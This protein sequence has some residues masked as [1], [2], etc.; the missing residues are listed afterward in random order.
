MRPLLFIAAIGAASLAMACHGNDSANAAPD[1]ALGA[2]GA[3]C[4]S[5]NDCDVPNHFYCLGP[6]NYYTGGCLCENAPTCTQDAQCDAG[7]VCRNVTSGAGNCHG[8]ESLLCAAPCT[9]DGD[10]APTDS[11]TADGHCA[12]RT[13][14][15]CPSYFSCST[16]ACTDPTC[17]SDTDC[18]GGYCVLGSC[19]VSL[20]ACTVPCGM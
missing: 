10:C 14:A 5:D 8:Y 6:Y 17:S 12:P 13:C 15:E 20:G 16:G 1:A 3:S 11:C 18:L 4:H 2:D 19:A 7:A 9:S